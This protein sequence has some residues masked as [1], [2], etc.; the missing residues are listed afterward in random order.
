MHAFSRELTVPGNIADLPA[1]LAFVEQACEQAGVDPAMCFD[2]QLV[3]EEA[4]SNVMEH[5]YEGKGG[6]FS[7]MF[8][9]RDR[10]VVITLRDRGR[11]FDPGQVAEPDIR[12][13]LAE[14]RIGGLGMH[15]MYQLMD[16]VRFSFSDGGNTLVMVKWNAVHDDV[17]GAPLRGGDG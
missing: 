2:L 1:I 13:P 5:A 4:C 12:R 15:L 14:R 16:S 8:E 9:T 3:A 7:V 17:V 11:P 10:D 6:Q